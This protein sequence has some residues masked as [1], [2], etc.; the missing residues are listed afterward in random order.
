MS[1][2]FQNLPTNS[3]SGHWETRCAIADFAMFENS[4]DI[5]SCSTEELNETYTRCFC[6]KP[7]TYA[8]ILTNK[9]QK[10]SIS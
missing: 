4:W 5:S 3:T 8:V 7:G 2:E 1:M 6:T 9:P 10:V